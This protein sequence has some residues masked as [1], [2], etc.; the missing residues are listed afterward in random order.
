MGSA[1]YAETLHLI[2]DGYI[3]EAEHNIIEHQLEQE[4]QRRE[5]D[6]N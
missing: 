5:D 2:S 4:A 1:K 3:R 6:D